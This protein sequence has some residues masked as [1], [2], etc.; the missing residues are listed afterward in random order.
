MAQWRK[1]VV[2]GSNAAL[3]Q[4]TASGA[5]VPK[6][7]NSVDLGTSSLEF[8]DLYIDG[9]ANLDTANISAGTITGITDLVV[10]DGGTGASTFTDGGV[11]LG[12]GTDAIT[13][14]AV[15]ANGQLL[16]GDNSTDPTVATLTATANETTV[17]NGAGSITIGIADDVTIPASLTVTTDLTVSGGDI[18]LT[19]AATDVDLIDNNSSA[20]S[21]DASGE[22][23]IL[24]IDTTNDK[25][26]VTMSKGLLISGAVTA[27]S[28]IS[29]STGINAASLLLDTQLAVAEGGTGATSLTDK[30]VLISQD[31]GTDAVGSL[32][33]T[34]NGEII[35]G[36]TNGPAVEAAA[37]VAG[38]GLTASAGDG[39]LAINLDIDSL[40]AE[41][42]ATGDTIAFNDDGDDGIHK[43]TVDDLFAIGPALVTEDAIADGDYILFLD[44]GSTGEANKEAIADVASLFAGTGLGAASS[45][46]SVAAAQTNITSII[47]ASLGKIGT[48]ASEEYV[49]FGTANEV[50]TF[51][52]NTERLSV[53]ANGIDVTGAVTISGNLDV[54]GTLTT[55]DSSNTTIADKFMILASGSAS[56]TDGGIIVQ[57]SNTAGYAL[58][59]DSGVDRWVFDADLAHNATN[60]GPDAYVGV[61]QTATTHGDSLAVPI[62]GGTTNGVGT[63]YVDTDDSEIWIYA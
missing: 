24:N 27:S 51:I 29:G 57:G 62:Y 32:A 49:T 3:N 50:N 7:D 59:Y 25:E 35:V 60:I 55:I 56:D 14:T 6:S 47:N 15:L 20:L 39:T 30:A 5:I 22:A 23:G 33:M 44:G 45:V 11:L 26:R 4:I 41:V 54:N 17:S 13:A 58:G 19:A 10:A 37:D 28:A 38:D 61:I 52:N 16:I 53:T 42:I 43:E 34:G 8:K 63:I 9:T 12:S 36:G 21:F 31:T 2:S 18:T 46:I 1:V 40:S 48:S